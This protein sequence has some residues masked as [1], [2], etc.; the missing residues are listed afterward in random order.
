MLVMMSAWELLLEEQALGP[1][2]HGGT[3]LSPW[4]GYQE[5]SEGAGSWS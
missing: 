2:D 3:A 1:C 5:V 4:S